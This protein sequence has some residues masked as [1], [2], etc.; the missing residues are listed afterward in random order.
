MFLFS[1]LQLDQ[2]NSVYVFAA[3]ELQLVTGVFV[4][5]FTENRFVAY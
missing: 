3:N 4:L 1:S 2:Y 5:F